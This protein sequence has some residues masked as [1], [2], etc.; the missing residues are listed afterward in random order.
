MRFIYIQTKNY[1][2]KFPKQTKKHTKKNIWSCNE[3]HTKAKIH[4]LENIDL[5]F[6]MLRTTSDDIECG[7]WGD[8]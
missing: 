3:M 7:M 4:V 5:G 2:Q 8:V 1:P 6:A